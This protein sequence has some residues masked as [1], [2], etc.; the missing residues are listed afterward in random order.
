MPLHC[1]IFKWSRCERDSHLGEMRIQCETVRDDQFQIIHPSPTEGPAVVVLMKSDICVNKRYDGHDTAWCT[2]EHSFM[3]T[4]QAQ[5]VDRPH[6]L[7]MEAPTQGYWGGLQVLLTEQGQKDRFF[8][9]WQISFVS[10]NM[11]ENIKDSSSCENCN[12]IGFRYMYHR[13]WF[14]WKFV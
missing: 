2:S 13:E 11:K 12:S 3:H 5:R 1:Y 14:I 10:R 9:V 7:E 8:D 6:G 4:F